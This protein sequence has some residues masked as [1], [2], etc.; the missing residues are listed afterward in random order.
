[1]M[2]YKEGVSPSLATNLICGYG[3]MADALVLGTN[4]FGV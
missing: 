3:G 4:V 1:M 2:S